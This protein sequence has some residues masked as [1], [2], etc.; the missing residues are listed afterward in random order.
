MISDGVST[1]VTGL[2]QLS[3]P[4]YAFR[5]VRRFGTQQVGWFIVT[6]FASLAVIHC[7]GPLRASGRG[8][9]SIL[10]TDLAYAVGSVL[11]LIGMCHVETMFK[12][13][14]KARSHEDSLRG[15]WDSHI[16][17]DRN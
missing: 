12:E 4:S 6:A 9:G 11:L 5:L 7:V 10:L 2:L 13:R 14:E 3:V 8:P 17:S 1:V 16:R 15:A